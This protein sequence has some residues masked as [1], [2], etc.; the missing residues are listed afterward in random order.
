MNL[1]IWANKPPQ[2]EVYY[3]VGLALD[4]HAT[5][6]GS[7]LVM[8]VLKE[9]NTQKKLFLRG[10]H[11][12]GRNPSRADTVLCNSDVSQ[13]HASIRWNGKTW[14]I[15][16]HSR[17]GTLLDGRRLVANEKTALATG[18]TIRFSL[19]CETGWVVET[20]DPPC[21]MLL[22]ANEEA[23]VIL[24]QGFHFLP[25]EDAALASVYLS[26]GSQWMWEDEQG[27]RILHDGDMVMV[28][29]QTWKFNAS[30]EIEVTSDL[31][32]QSPPALR[33][34]LF[35][36]AV[37]QNEEH[38]YLSI[39]IDG[40]VINLGERTHH[41]SLLILARKRFEDAERGIDVAS[42][43]WISV[44]DLSRMLGLDAPHVNTLLFRGRNQIAR[45]CPDESSLSNVIERRRGEV[46]FGAFRFQIVRGV[47]VEA[48]FEPPVSLTLLGR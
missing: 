46:R 26:A 2:K 10:L 35:D 36:F 12:F 44:D 17:N 9:E 42:Q 4:D 28:G 40:N 24:L 29:D 47:Q 27:H 18:Q 31:R 16:D 23:P 43:G 32:L 39:A 3:K 15:T 22:P 30:N 21:P 11:M 25:D 13:I 41:Y 5:L 20:L 34:V 7:E 8:A 45:E 33:T 48:V 19:A 37:S 6:I 38:I 1:F 14:E